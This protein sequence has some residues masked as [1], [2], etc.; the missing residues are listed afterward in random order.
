MRNDQLIFNQFSVPGVSRDET[1][2]PYQSIGQSKKSAS[3]SDYLAF[4]GKHL[5]FTKTLSASF[6][7]IAFAAIFVL[8]S[9]A[10]AGNVVL[11][12]TSFTMFFVSL[13][14]GFSAAGLHKS[15][16]N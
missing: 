6:F 15:L 5:V 16:K 13:L 9:S 12:S 3:K 10:K 7:T 14:V 1:I 11:M 2:T 4:A 8:I